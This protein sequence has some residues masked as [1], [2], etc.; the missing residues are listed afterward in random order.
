LI[1]I[2]ENPVNIFLVLSIALLSVKEHSLMITL[3]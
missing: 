2:L 1:I 3:E